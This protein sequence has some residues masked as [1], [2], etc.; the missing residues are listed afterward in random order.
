MW[1]HVYL[2]WK[3]NFNSKNERKISFSY[4]SKASMSFIPIRRMCLWCL[5][6]KIMEIITWIC[7]CL[8]R[9]MNINSKNSRI[10]V[11]LMNLKH[12]YHL[13]Q[14]EECVYGAQSW[15]DR[16]LL[17]ESMFIPIE[18]WTLNLKMVIGGAF[19]MKRRLQYHLY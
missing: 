7:V 18:R 4:E 2:N 17:C 6:L 13:P 1:I 14:W 9:C 15:K 5:I 19:L 12:Q 16:K 11:L 8:N 10:E 3:M